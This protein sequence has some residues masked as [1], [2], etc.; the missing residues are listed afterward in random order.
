MAR[1][2]FLWY[3]FSVNKQPYYIDNNGVVVE[4][5]LNWLKADG[6]PAHLEFSPKGWPDT[7]FKYGRNLVYWG[8]VRDISVGLVFP[9]D[10]MKILKWI[11]QNF[12]YEGVVFLG[13]LKLNRSVLPYKYESWNLTEINLTKYKQNKIEVSVDA[14]EGGISKLLKSYENQ[15][16]EIEMGLDV[17]YIQMDGINLLGKNTY[18]ILPGIHTPIVGSPSGGPPSGDAAFFVGLF[19][20]AIEG[21]SP[22]IDFAD[23][24]H[25]SLATQ[26]FGDSSNWFATAR[27]DNPGLVILEIRG[28]LKLKLIRQD[29]NTD[30]TIM[31][32]KWNDATQI[33]TSNPI[34]QAGPF[35]FQNEIRD[36][37]IDANIAMF[38]GDKLGL[39]IFIPGLNEAS[40][41]EI[42]DG[43]E[44]TVS[45]TN[46]YKT[47]YVKG[48]YLFDLFKKIVEKMTAGSFLLPNADLVYHKSSWLSNKRDIIVTCGD[49]LRELENPLIKTSL[50]D[51]FSSVRI[52]SSSLGIEANHL[53][54]ELWEYVFGPNVMLDLG[55]VSKARLEVTEDLLFNSIKVG[56]PVK[57]YNDVNGRFEWNQEQIW[58]TPATK[59]QK[60][61]DLSSVY[62]VD[63]YGAEFQRLLKDRD[64][65]DKE[66]DN[67]P[68]MINVENGVLTEPNLGINYQRLNRPAYTTFS[69]APVGVFNTEISP[70]R[71][72]INNGSQIRG[73]LGEAM[74]A[75]QLVLTRAEKNKDLVTDAHVEKDPI[76]ISSLNPAKFSHNYIYFETQVPDNLLMLIDAYPYGKIRFTVLGREF[77]GYLMDGSIK[78]ANN[79]QQSWK[80]LSAIENDLSLF[81]EP[82]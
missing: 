45:F 5:D 30:F 36:I 67:D 51:F 60:E 52:F 81:Y 28:T 2:T 47:T 66:G 37:N 53:F 63:C 4:G 25:L 23:Q 76:G 70:K 61:L 33:R 14:L 78:P 56:G 29:I 27:T 49:A 43:S 41:W 74:G 73:I 7:T 57:E 82:L 21:Y 50:T 34:I 13:L 12:G 75:K 31:Y 59:V 6:Q 79:D 62:R 32:E 54:I 48:L 38:P 71:T 64:T 35:T 24:Q 9:K 8:L 46:R 80:V 68:W 55:E 69:G 26:P 77:F 65:T 15:Q 20:N 42:L 17:K 18:T 22:G 39:T 1:K 40:W 16:Y 44:I 72:I 58:S 3:L 19:S 11:Y 10:G